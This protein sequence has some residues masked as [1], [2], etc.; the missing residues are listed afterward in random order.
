MEV[1]TQPLD[2]A[3]TRPSA[4][5][6]PV[7]LFAGLGL[8]LWAWGAAVPEPA[9]LQIF[10]CLWLLGVGILAARLLFDGLPQLELRV[11]RSV[12]TFAIGVVGAAAV[13][14]MPWSDLGSVFWYQLWFSVPLATGLGLAAFR[15]SGGRRH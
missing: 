7:L 2:R 10:L 13:A 11:S 4:L 15:P 12:L 9:R 5:G 1:H 6:G 8:T 3:S 14:T